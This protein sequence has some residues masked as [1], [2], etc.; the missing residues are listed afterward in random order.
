MKNQDN[1]T[2][3]DSSGTRTDK[4]ADYETAIATTGFGWFHYWLCK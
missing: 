4:R 2:I 1:D 3:S